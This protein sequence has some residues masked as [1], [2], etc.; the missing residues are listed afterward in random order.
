MLNAYHLPPIIYNYFMLITSCP[1]YNIRS[2]MLITCCPESRQSLPSNHSTVYTRSLARG[3]IVW[4]KRD[5]ALPWQGLLIV[6]QWCDWVLPYYVQW[7]MAFMVHVLIINIIGIIFLNLIN[8]KSHYMILYDVHAIK[9]KTG[10]FDLQK[11]QS[12]LDCPTR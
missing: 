11:T 5:G 1:D 6:I 4:D 12:S 2:R 7:W 9:F 10:V 3:P 8:T